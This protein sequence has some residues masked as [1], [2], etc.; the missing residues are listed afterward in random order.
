MLKMS[1]IM[2]SFVLLSGC[3][4]LTKLVLDGQK[5]PINVYNDEKEVQ[6][7]GAIMVWEPHSSAAIIGQKGN[8][9]VLAASGAKSISESS[10]AILKLQDTLKGV[11]AETKDKLTE[12][13]AKLSVSTAQSTFADVALFH[14]CILDQNGAFDLQKGESSKAMLNAY[15]ETIEAVRSIKKDK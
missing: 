10:E 1:S 14:L 8:R 5:I 13:F 7:S 3:A 11:D 9:C 2:L 6:K 4:D 15:L 12:T